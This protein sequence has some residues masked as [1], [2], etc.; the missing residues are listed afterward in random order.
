[1]R[2]RGISLICAILLTLGIT[3]TVIAFFIPSKENTLLYTFDTKSA[4]SVGLDLSG[5]DIIIS[6]TE[7][8]SLSVR[9]TDPSSKL[10]SAREKDG[11]IF[12]TDSVSAIELL[13]NPFRL[14]YSGFSS[15]IFSLI[16]ND[17]PLVEIFIPSDTEISSLSLDLESSSLVTDIGKCA[18]FSAKTK[19]SDLE[20]KTLDAESGIFR[21]ESS[22]IKLSL[23]FSEKEVSFLIYASECEITKNGKSDT[24]LDASESALCDIFIFARNSIISLDFGK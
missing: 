5:C 12:I 17:R 1:M 20:I 2:K 4:V 23:P 8:D 3:L 22:L 16:R 14:G 19:D 24:D 7:S 10:I 21:A 15:I 11:E 13:K 6:R 9:I 18:V